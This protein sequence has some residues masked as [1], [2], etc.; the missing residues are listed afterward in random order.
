VTTLPRRLTARAS[1]AFPD[2]PSARGWAETLA[3]GAL[4]GG[5]GYAFGR[6]TGCSAAHRALPFAR[7]RACSCSRRRRS[8]EELWFRALM[9]P[10]RQEQPSELCGPA[11]VH[12]RLHALARA[13]GA[14]DPAERPADFPP[15]R[16]PR[17]RGAEGL[18]CGWLRRRT[19]S[20]WPGVALH[21]AEVMVWKT[22]LGGPALTDLVQASGKLGSTSRRP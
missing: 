3:I 5:A 22:W 15:P 13:H 2:H 10:S 21:W 8:G 20:V 6:L 19:G 12:C 1:L 16:L 17:H 14:H 4:A 9:T 18:V 7:G 11:P